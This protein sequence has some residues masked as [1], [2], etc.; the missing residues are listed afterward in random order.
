MPDCLKKSVTDPYVKLSIWGGATS[1]SLNITKKID[2][3]SPL[4]GA[5]M[6]EEGRRATNRRGRTRSLMLMENPQEV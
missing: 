4:A 2:D 1:N 5:V 6:E 3:L